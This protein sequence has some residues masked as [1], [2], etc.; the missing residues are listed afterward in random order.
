MP[1]NISPYA[2]LCACKPKPA[3]TIVTAYD[4]YSQAQRSEAQPVLQNVPVPAS[5]RSDATNPPQRISSLPARRTHYIAD[6]QARHSNACRR[7]PMQNQ[8]L[9]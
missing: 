1:E 6:I 8:P 5:V 9:T 3:P 2:L 4:L 7:A